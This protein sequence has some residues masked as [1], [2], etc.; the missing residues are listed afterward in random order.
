MPSFGRFIC[1]NN[2]MDKLAYHYNKKKKPAKTSGK[3]LYYYPCT[4]TDSP[5]TYINGRPYIVIEVSEA[6]W[7]ALF[8]L[9]R[10]E[11]NN[12]HKY[13]RHTVRFSDKDEDELTPKQQERRIDKS[14]P[15]NVFA[16]ER[17]DRE[18]LFANLPQQDREILKIMS[19]GKTQKEAA[20]E[21]GVT[22]GYISTQLKH[23]NCSVDDYIFNTGT[24]EEIV[25][26]C[27]NRFVNDGEMPYFLDVELEFV[28][29]ALFNDLMPFL[30]WFYSMGELFRH[31]LT[32]YYFDND[33]MDDEIAEYLKTASEKAK[34]HYE[35]YYGD[36]PPIVGAVYIRLCKEMERRKEIGLR[37]SYKLYTS[38]FA[39]V[40]KITSRLNIGVEEFLTQ[41][42]YPYIAKWRN[43]RIRQFYKYYTGKSLKK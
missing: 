25:W 37:E 19:S 11:Y 21:L 22:Q 24:R 17:R 38:I 26:H 7:E 23:A 35:D 27:W 5:N 13:Q 3:F 2:A 43:K 30:H 28:L 15:F 33:K 9:D 8:E 1:Y 40:E 36:Q 29:R 16:D 14:I 18:I 34:Q 42:F 20:E 10:L 31:I 39:A 12:T 6:E 32:Y 41:R 4:E